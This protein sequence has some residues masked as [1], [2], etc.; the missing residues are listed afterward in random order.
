MSDPMLDGHSHG[1]PEKA[2]GDARTSQPGQRP[3]GDGHAGGNDGPGRSRLQSRQQAGMPESQA[4]E[5]R[6]VISGGSGFHAADRR[7]PNCRHSRVAL[8]TLPNSR[9]PRES[10]DPGFSST[11]FV[12]SEGRSR[13]MMANP[14]TS[15]SHAP[16]VCNVKESK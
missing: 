4:D 1:H 14:S 13:S 9:H 2:P 7:G 16:W 8:A 10:G 3:A 5:G 6:E 15:Q 12:L 11:P